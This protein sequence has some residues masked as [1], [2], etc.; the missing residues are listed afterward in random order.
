MCDCTRK[1]WVPGGPRRELRS[2][3][4]GGPAKWGPTIWRILHD[5]AEATDERAGWEELGRVLPGS[6]PCVECRVHFATWIAANPWSMTGGARRWM[7]AAHN[8]VNV[9]LGRRV[10]TLE[11]LTLVYR[12]CDLIMLVLEIQD[13]LQVIESKG[14]L[15]AAAVRVMKGLGDIGI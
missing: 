6:L 7:L 13:T 10:W 8:A 11:E 14:M 2:S 4:D 3:L 9:R 5:L 12:G 15:G 1:G